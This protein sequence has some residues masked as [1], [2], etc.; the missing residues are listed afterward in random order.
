MKKEDKPTKSLVEFVT[1]EANGVELVTVVCFNPNDSGNFFNQLT[2][3]TEIP[4]G[5]TGE[6]RKIGILSAI[7]KNGLMQWVEME[8]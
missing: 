5:L 6:K 4:S 1:N 3:T 2:I 8:L 7:Q